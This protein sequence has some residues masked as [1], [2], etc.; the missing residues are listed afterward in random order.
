M[1]MVLVDCRS[2]HNS[3]R[4]TVVPK[5]VAPQGT[6][7]VDCVSEVH[8]ILWECGLPHIPR[9]GD[10]PTRR[11]AILCTLYRRAKC[12]NGLERQTVTQSRTAD[13]I[14]RGGY[15]ECDAQ[16]AAS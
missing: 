8:T 4:E 13:V 5:G 1:R 15:V 3:D 10:I 7:L 2:I 12:C 11:R 14:L 6:A 9:C 16:K